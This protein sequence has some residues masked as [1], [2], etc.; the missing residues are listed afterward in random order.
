[1]G[2]ICECCEKET[3]IY[4]PC[5]SCGIYKCNPYKFMSNE[6]VICTDCLVNG[7]SYKVFL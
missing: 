2:N 5:E 7:Y 3:K 4:V 6:Y 1:M